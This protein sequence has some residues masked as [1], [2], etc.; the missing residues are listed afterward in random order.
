MAIKAIC[1]ACGQ[2]KRNP[3]TECKACGFQPETEYQMARALI[4]SPPSSVS[5]S[6]IGRDQESL[7]ALSKQITGGRPYAFDP[8]EVEQALAAYKNFSQSETEKKKRNKKLMV[9]ALI[10][11]ILITGIAGYFFLV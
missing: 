5:N 11:I 9:S 1:V 8:K 6:Q 2:A 3:Y 4:F 7:K 10:L